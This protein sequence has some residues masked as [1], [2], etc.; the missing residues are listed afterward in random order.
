M[1]KPIDFYKSELLINE[2]HQ[3]HVKNQLFWIAMLRLFVFIA[4]IFVIYYFFHDR[5]LVVIASIIG[6]VIFLYLVKK[7]ESLKEKNAIKKALIK[8]NKTEI[9]VLEKNAYFLDTGAEFRNSK[10]KFSYDIDLF[11]KASFFQ[12]INRT[13]TKEGKKLLA[14]NLSSN[15]IE[16]V[17]EKQ[18]TIQELSEMIKWR[19]SFAAKATVIKVE[20][21]ATSIINW[22]KGYEGF[23]PLSMKYIP[24]LFLSFSGLLFVLNF[25]N[26]ISYTFIIS[27]FLIGLIISSLYVKKVNKLA[28]QASAAK[29][30]FR[31]YF[32]LLL[33]IENTEF[34]SHYLVEKKQLL[35]SNKK[36]ASM[37]FKKLSKYLD[38][39]DQRNNI[40]FGVLANGFALWD[41]KQV[42]KIENWIA[43]YANHVE[44]WFDV[45]SFFDSQN[46]LANYHYNN[47]KHVF[48]IIISDTNTIIATDLGHPLLKPKKRIDNDFKIAK[49]DFFIITGANMA[50]KSTFLR[51][52]S[53]SIVMANTGLPVCAKSYSYTPVKII[54][55]M[56]TDDSL[57][58]DESYFFSELKRLKYIIDAIAEEVHFIVLDE[59]LKGTNSTDKAIGSRKF[60]KK[61][62]DSKSTGI[63]ATHDLSLCEISG[64]LEEVKNYYFD[65]EIIDDELFFDYKMKDG[66][67]QNMN[68]SFLL[69]KMGIV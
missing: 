39:L 52:V 63:I 57:S 18:K 59:I 19:Q 45:I 28:Q 13:V 60:V 67:C 8:I 29:D 65:A 12:H 49:E 20:T 53:L 50:G 33:Q 15:H 2:Q 24:V 21:K 62:V 14:N 46:S 64:E 7:Y 54:T 55:S 5:Q 41:I 51:A 23:L 4:T 6:L 35:V 68:A 48:P 25:S 17:E 11:G 66:I 42:S 69:K 31:Q 22:M 36:S 37:I 40:L 3:T 61:L 26:V 32:K 27:W 38:A 43:N 9:K 1:S 34:K 58:D 30:T 44:E 56:R 47:P 10:H 16:S